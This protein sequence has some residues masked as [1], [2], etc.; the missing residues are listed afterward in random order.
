MNSSFRVIKLPLVVVLVAVLAL[1]GFI[2][3]DH[4]SKAY[5]KPRTFDLIVYGGTP[6]GVAAAVSAE[7]HG[8]HVL[9][10][11]AEPTVGGA[12]SNGLG[13]TDIGNSRAISGI[14]REFLNRVHTHYKISDGWRV[15]PHVAEAILR[16]MLKMRHIELVTKDPLVSAQRT[17]KKI[18]CISLRDKRSYC[19]SI[20]I[21]ASYE[22]DLLAAAGATF[23]LGLSDIFTHREHLSALR[24]IDTVLK[25]P[26]AGPD[27]VALLKRNPYIRFLKSI[28]RSGTI[29]QGEPSMA[30]RLCLSHSHKVAFSPGPDYAHYLHWE[31]S[32]AAFSVSGDLSEW[33]D[34]LGNVSPVQ[35]QIA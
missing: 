11:S 22:G 16:A 28:S 17:G 7:V 19:G 27:V 13:A 21:D 3:L 34:S 29:P 1:V 4:D 33:S 25:F 14:A 10:I 30:W 23:H 35:L 26:M 18:S 24:Q 6:S 20:F 8:M 2:S 5:S 15:Q 12:I 31:M 32:Q 9:L